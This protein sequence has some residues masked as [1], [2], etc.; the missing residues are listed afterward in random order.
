MS[1]INQII[2]FVFFLFATPAV[3]QQSAWSMFGN[4]DL[5]QFSGVVITG[6]SLKPIPYTNIRV[7]GSNYGTVSNYDGFF[8]FVAHR[9]DRILFTAVGYQDSYYQIPDTLS[10]N[11]YSLFQMMETDT[12]LLTVTV[13]YPW[14]TVEDLEFAIVQHRVPENDYDRAM[15]NLALEEMKERGRSLD[16]DGAMNYRYDMSEVV[17]KSYYNG[18]YMP[19]QILNPFAWAKFIEAWKDGKFKKK[20]D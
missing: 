17:R 18:Q 8:S 5:V 10:Q 13:I 12:I 15:K 20:K 19:V 16:Y 6:D 1:R 3:G 11:R 9:G 4:D 14:P 2:A 7:E